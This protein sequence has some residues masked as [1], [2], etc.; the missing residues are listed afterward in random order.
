MEPLGSARS[1]GEL[2]GASVDATDLRSGQPE[3]SPARGGGGSGGSGGSGGGGDMAQ[4]SSSSDAEYTERALGRASARLA[5]TSSDA[6]DGDHEREVAD[7]RR[8]AHDSFRELDKNDDGHVTRA[9]LIRALRLPKHARLC[10]VGVRS[11]SLRR[12]LDH[13]EGSRISWNGGSE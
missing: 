10:E 11:L 7:L 12:G 13:P 9:E 4:T 3:A 5:S 1:A 8:Y 6:N 2:T